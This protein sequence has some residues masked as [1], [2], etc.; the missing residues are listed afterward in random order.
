MK[1]AITGG[2]GSGKSYV[3]RLLEKRGMEVYDC[4]AA[5]KRLMRTSAPLRQALRQL[6]GD[7]VY[8]GTTL[9]K[10][11]LARYLLASDANKQAVNGVVHPAVAADFMASGLTWLESAILFDSG[12]NR[13]V[14]FDRVVCVSAPQEVRVARVMAR[15]GIGRDQAI[16]WIDRQ[17]AQAEVE[18]RSDFVIVNDGTAPLDAQI[19]RLLRTFGLQ[20]LRRGGGPNVRKNINDKQIKKKTRNN[21]ETILSIAGKPG[22]YKLVSRGKMNLIVEAIDETHRRLPAFAS[23]RVTS[24]AD[25]AMYTDA[26]DIPLW[27]VLKSLGEK[28]QSKPC[29][30]NYKKCSAAELHDFFAEVLPAYD[31][32]RVHDSDIKKLIQWYNILVG[33]GITDF[34][35]T[36]AP[37][38]GDNID[39]RKDAEAAE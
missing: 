13:R 2:I 6:V 7:D 10:A 33:N 38:E 25:I 11:V 16:Q 31:R 30:L 36:L 19:D 27:K 26:E 17:M 22:L 35:K 29:S 3:C 37:T 4:D 39:D 12:F 34:E 1:I 5:A 28:E 18:R 14:A 32:D 21:M 15:D 8:D 23:D 9:Q 20:D 24:L